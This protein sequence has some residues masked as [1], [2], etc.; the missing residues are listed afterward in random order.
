MN[1]EEFQ[2]DLPP[3]NLNGD[4]LAPNPSERRRVPSSFPLSLSKRAQY[5]CIYTYIQCSD[6]YTLSR[7]V[8]WRRKRTIENETARGL[9]IQLYDSKLECNLRNPLVKYMYLCIS[10]TAG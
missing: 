8:N 3:S 2:L 7:S 5:T 10:S 6:V 4:D 9:E 1:L